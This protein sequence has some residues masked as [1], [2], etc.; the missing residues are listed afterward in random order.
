MKAGRN[1]KRLEAMCREN[2]ADTEEGLGEDGPEIP[3]GETAEQGHYFD[4]GT[5]HP[6]DGGLWQR[7]LCLPCHRRK[8]V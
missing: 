1:P 7:E 5:V 6:L 8:L 4:R 3:Q 2:R